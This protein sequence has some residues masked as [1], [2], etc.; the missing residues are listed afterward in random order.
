M[1]MTYGGALVMPSSY[2]M[3][4]EEEMMYLEG[5]ISIYNWL[6]AG[7]INLT[8][9]LL[10]V[11]GARKAASFFAGQVK[12]YGAKAAGFYM[13]EKLRKQM[14]AKG[15]AAGVAAGLCGIAAAGITI[16]TW[17]VDPG[18][19]LASFIDSKDCNPNNGCC[20]F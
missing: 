18:G 13:S 2:A 10:V 17:A 15:I 12:K 14:I 5:G 7:V 16:L 4:D 3:M 8:I 20:D 1:E 11:G 6:V 9:D 19:Q